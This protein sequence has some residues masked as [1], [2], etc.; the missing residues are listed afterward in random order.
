MGWLDN[1]KKSKNLEGKRILITGVGFSEYKH[2]FTAITSDED[3]S[4]D[5]YAYNTKARKLQRLKL[6]IGA[7]TAFVLAANGATVHLV[8]RTEEKLKVIKER[9]KDSLNIPEER[10]EYSALDLLDQEQVKKFIKTIPKD[11]LLYWVQSVGLGAG[12]YK[13]KD[14]NPYLLVDN[15]PLELL[16]KES[17]TVL[18]ATHLMMQELLPVFRKQDKTKVAIVT[19]MSGIRAY[20]GGGTHCAAKGAI[21]MY[22]NALRIELC[23]ERIYITSIRPGGT[24]TGGYDNKSVQEAVIRAAKGYDCD[25]TKGIRLIPPIAVA[26]AI[27]LALS[28]E[29]HIGA[30]NLVGEG[31]FPHQRS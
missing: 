2:K 26:E 4:N 18:T 11:K 21:D 16:Q 24:D 23:N 22:A 5:I 1:I 17:T 10:I 7:A 12:S 25:W 8:S 30:I 15:I 28:S 14:G 29:S 31:Q 6:N 27:S 9:I 19:S 13:V 20:V 3:S